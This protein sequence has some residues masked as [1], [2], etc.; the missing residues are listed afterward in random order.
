MA[1]TKRDVI[2]LDLANIEESA[3]RLREEVLTSAS[4]PDEEL[5][6]KVRDL[7]EE[8]VHL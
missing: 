2:L 5:F 7:R 3:K 1:A 8:I 6:A 4:A